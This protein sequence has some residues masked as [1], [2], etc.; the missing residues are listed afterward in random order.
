MLHKHKNAPI[1]SHARRKCCYLLTHLRAALL[2]CVLATLPAMAQ[3]Q[4]P[5]VFSA[6]NSASYGA[7]IAQGSL[8]VVYGQN[9]GPAQLIQASSYPL[10][11][12][13]GGS[14]IYV[15]SGSTIFVCPMV[16]S[17]A[18]AAAAVMPS[19]VPPGTGMLTLSYNGTATPFPLSVNV[20]P[21]TVG[22]YTVGSSGSGT[23]IFTGMN[24][25][26]KTFAASAKSGDIV[27]AWATGLGPIGG[28]DNMVPPN[29]PNF[30][31]VEVF[32]GT[33]AANVLY[34]GRSGCCVALDQISFEV[35][36]GVSGCYVPVAVRSGGAISNFVSITVSSGGGPCSDTAPTV[37]VSIMNQAAAGQTVK[38]AALAAGPVS[39]LRGLGFDVKPYLAQ[40]LS[41]LLRTKVSQDD[42]AK[43]LMAA[44]SRNQRELLHAMIKYA[45]AWKALSPAAKAAVRAVLSANQE[46]VVADFGQ[47]NA[48]A[49]L[50]AVLGGLFPSQG[51]CVPLPS[52]YATRSGSGLDAGS[53][54]SLGAGWI[55]EPDAKQSGTISSA[56]REHPHRSESSNRHLHHHRR[57]RP[58]CERLQRI[59]ERWCKRSVDEQSG[60]RQHRPE[61]ASDRHLVGRPR[62]GF[63]CGWGLRGFG[64]YGPGGFRLHR[65]YQRGFLH[66]SQ[67]H[68]LSIAF[69]RDR[70]GDVH[71]ATS[72]IAPGDHPR[73]RSGLF[74]GWQQ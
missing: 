64:H 55:M 21:S 63:G 48:P 60:H 52:E 59:V 16:Y 1:L 39:V 62:S 14:S 53:A 33:Q 46:G 74:H 44:Q 38:A 30:P 17:V 70:R 5:F 13:V 66:H 51:T 40:T 58:R 67:F 15:T 68:P 45:A 54:L 50:A 32:V 9:I 27:T 31:G 34:A 23:G 56:V 22:I 24:G 10:P 57:R 3:Q 36:S 18:G 26:L 37:P 35:P 47:F 65:G 28:P 69:R 72:V 71:H 2:G 41:K 29:F 61:P 7:N 8:F 11:A 42:L 12:Q 73:T 20:V 25:A 43:L 4:T 49:A 6:A 19:N